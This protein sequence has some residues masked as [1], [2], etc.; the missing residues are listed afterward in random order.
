MRSLVVKKL[1]LSV[2]AF[3]LCAGVGFAFVAAQY[4]PRIQPGVRVGPVDVGGLTKDDARRKLRLWW[5]T[6]RRTTVRLT[7]PS[8]REQPEE[9]TLT[10][11]GFSLDDTASVRDLPLEPFGEAVQRSVGLTTPLVQVFE[12]VVRFDVAALRSV[13]DL[14]ARQAADKR[15]ARAF[16]RGTAVIREPEQAGF[17]LDEGSFREAALAAKENGG[18]GE[19]PL[20]VADKRVPDAELE[21]ITDVIGRFQTR[22]PASQT[23]RNNNIRVAASKIHGRI[24]MPG[25][26]FSFNAVVGRRT[27]EEGFRLAPVFV[28]GRREPGVGGGICQVSTTLYNAALYANLKIVQRQNHSLPVAYV[29][30]GRDA[31]VAYGVIDLVLE[32][33]LDHPVALSAEVGPSTVSFAVLGRKVPGQTVAIVPSGLRSWDRGVTYVEDRSLPPGK[34]RV[35]DKGG[36]GRSVDVFRVVQING[37][38]V[39]R[40]SLGRSYYRG[41]PKLIAINRS[42]PDPRPALPAGESATAPA[43]ATPPAAEDSQPPV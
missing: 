1:G 10:G 31:A 8:L 9:R 36:M 29:P 2:I 18:T 43:G 26:R 30:A 37:E 19:L 12:P 38:V 16:L 4:E 14:V 7:N 42:K 33:P 32:N 34:Q 5:E 27:I 25:D 20:V 39:R 40:E 24:L 15:P 13:A 41:S 28:N 22:F 6:E 23:A 17:K 11:W 35:I 3:A 21:K